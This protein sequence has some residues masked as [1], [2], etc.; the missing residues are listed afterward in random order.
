MCLDQTKQIQL[1]FI[2]APYFL[3]IITFFGRKIKRYFLSLDRPDSNIKKG[4]YN[5][6]PAYLEYQ[7]YLG[8]NS[9]AFLAQ[10][11][12]PAELPARSAGAANDKLICLPKKFSSKVR[13]IKKRRQQSKFSISA[14]WGEGEREKKCEKLFYFYSES[15]HS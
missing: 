15:S 10:K 1:A 5:A 2:S 4:A 8:T 3:Q 6:R 7:I 12:A 13:R 14:C 9:P 11:E